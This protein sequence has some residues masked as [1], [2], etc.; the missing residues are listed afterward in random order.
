M[1]VI[2]FMSGAAAT[3]ALA[4]P[5]AARAAP[6]KITVPAHLQFCVTSKPLD[7]SAYDHPEVREELF[8]FLYGQIEREALQADLASIG[9][10]FVDAVTR[11]P[12]VPQTL[13]SGVPVSPSQMTATYVVRECANVP[14]RGTPPLPPSGVVEVAAKVVYAT[15]CAAASIEACKRNLEQV[16]RQENSAPA[17]MARPIIWRTRQALT[18]EDSDANL[19]ES[20]SDTKIRTLRDD[21]QKVTVPVDVVVESAELGIADNSK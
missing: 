13:A 18:A 17:D 19:V 8:Q 1:K 4:I 7:V 20:L 16:V 6:Q 14:A 5:C 9:V 11:G 21:A 15:I 12:D 2:R 10:A 3:L